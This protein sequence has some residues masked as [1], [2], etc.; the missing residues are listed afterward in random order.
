MPAAQVHLSVFRL[1]LYCTAIIMLWFALLL[2]YM[3]FC[4]G[5][6]VIEIISCSFMTLIT[7]KNAHGTYC[8]SL[9]YL[10]FIPN[11]AHQSF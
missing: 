6:Q 9:S 3:L 1:T 10:M 2:N 11:D 5:Q 4:H 8:D 7:N